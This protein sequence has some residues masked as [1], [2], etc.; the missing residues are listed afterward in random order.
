M[1]SVSKEKK[2]TYIT[3]GIV[4]GLLLGTALSTIINL[5]FDFD[6][7]WAWGVS[8]GFGMLL[9]IVVGMNIRKK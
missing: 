9:G 1:T 6:A 8:P 5:M 2:D 4:F 3:E 7:L